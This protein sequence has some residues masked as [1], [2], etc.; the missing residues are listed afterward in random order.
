M[1]SEELPT[2]VNVR[3][4]ETQE[5]ESYIPRLVGLSNA[6]HASITPSSSTSGIISDQVSEDGVESS[7]RCCSTTDYFTS[8]QW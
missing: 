4:G 5:H 8:L 1:D 6:L 3:N 7:C 2:H